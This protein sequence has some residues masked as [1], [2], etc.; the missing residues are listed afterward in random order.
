[1][2]SSNPSDLPPELQKKRKLTLPQVAELTSV[3][4]DTI[5]RRYSHLIDK[6]SPRRDGMSVENAL[7]IGSMPKDAA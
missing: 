1:M 7:S 5:R 4:E 2:S 3:S 6:L